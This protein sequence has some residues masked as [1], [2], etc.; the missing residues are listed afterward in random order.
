MTG[1]LGYNTPVI[2]PARLHGAG[3]LLI[4]LVVAA[5]ARADVATPPAP[6]AAP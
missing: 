4:A 5:T 1:A 6:D 2:R 3:L